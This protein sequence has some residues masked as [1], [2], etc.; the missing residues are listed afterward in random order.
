LL[1]INLEDDVFLFT[2]EKIIHIK[3][4]QVKE[5]FYTNFLEVNFI[6]PPKSPS[7]IRFKMNKQKFDFELNR[8]DN[9]GVI[10]IDF[11]DFL[12]KKND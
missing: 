7:Y 2:E 10:R 4:K 11:V 12:L 8:K 3:K 1:K 5:Y 9:L 6:D